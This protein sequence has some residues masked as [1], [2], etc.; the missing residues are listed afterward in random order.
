MK[1]SIDSLQPGRK[2]K[3][4]NHEYLI[5]EIEFSNIESIDPPLGHVYLIAHWAENGRI[6]KSLD[7]LI[8]QYEPLTG[9]AMGAHEIFEYWKV[10]MGRL[11]AKP[12]PARIKVIT[13]RFKEGY[14][15]DD[16]KKAIDGCFDTAWNMGDNPGKKLYNDITLICRSGDKLEYFRDSCNVEVQHG[17]SHAERSNSET[18]ELLSII[19][20]GGNDDKI[21]GRNESTIPKQVECN[22]GYANSERGA[23]GEFPILVRE[24]KRPNN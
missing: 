2:W 1:L 12:I 11:K 21:L 9:E 24:D 22:R 17:K 23:V 13:N 3:Q 8:K 16:I 14:T 19:R 20:A 6:G 5:A 10:K 15:V 4:N 18:K 7:T